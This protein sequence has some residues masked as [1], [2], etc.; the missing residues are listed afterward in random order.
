[1]VRVGDTVRKPWL[2]TSN[3]TVDYLEALRAKGVDLPATHGRDELGRM[4]LEFVPGE[5]AQEYVPLA[6]ETVAQVGA[7]VRSTHD[8]S[9]WLP[10]PD[11]WEV[12]LPA[13]EPDLV[14]HNDLAPWNLIIDGDRLVFIDWDGAGPSTRL[15]DLAYAAV[16]FGHLF[17]EADVDEASA[18]LGAFVDGYG[19]DQEL[20]D[21]L[22]RAM[23]DRANAM[24]ELLRRSHETGR[25]PWGS[26]YVDG[27]GEHWS[28]TVDFVRQHEEVWARA[29]GAGRGPVPPSRPRGAR[30]CG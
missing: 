24:H 9:E 29:V 8:A 11:D 28:G 27:H 10:V 19:A 15:W 17:P 20:R 18:R 13:Q 14:C 2:P 12:L 7:L 30:V 3:R 23:A 4:V 25:E 1:M 21:A 16:A 6:T 5:L 22:P 26:M